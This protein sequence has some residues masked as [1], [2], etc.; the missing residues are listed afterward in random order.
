MCYTVETLLAYTLESI[1]LPPNVCGFLEGKS[2]HA[3]ASLNVHNA[4]LIQ[5]GSEGKI[6]LEI[7]SAMSVGLYA[8]MPVAQ[9][10]LYDL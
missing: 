1:R 3:R 7:T 10:L 6:M 2:R 5:P 9:L 4:P 8:E